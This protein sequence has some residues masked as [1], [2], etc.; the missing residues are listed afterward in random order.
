MSYELRT[1]VAA[2]IIAVLLAMV[3]A[4]QPPMSS[5]W[6]TVGPVTVTHFNGG[7]G[8]WH[9]ELASDVTITCFDP[10]GAIGLLWVT[11]SGVNQ[12]AEYL[13]VFDV[14]GGATTTFAF[15]QAGCK[16]DLN[17][18]SFR[19]TVTNHGNGHQTTGYK[20]FSHP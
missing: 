6:V 1:I 19:V 17:P 7:F 4:Q 11:P 10:S 2:A 12:P 16:H 13:L 18:R 9:D 20:N 15:A 5:P 14:P 3:P 8:G